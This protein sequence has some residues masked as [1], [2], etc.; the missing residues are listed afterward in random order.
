MIPTHALTLWRPWCWAICHAGKD[1]ENRPWKPWPSFL[2]AGGFVAIHSGAR[3]DVAG[4]FH[5]RSMHTD[6]VG[7]E[8][9][10][11]PPTKDEWPGGRIV[12]IARV[13][14]WVT[15]TNSRSGLT[16]ADAARVKDSDWFFGP[17]GWVL[18]DVLVL[19]EP[20]ACKGAQGLWRIPTDMVAKLR[21]QLICAVCGTELCRDGGCQGCKL[22]DQMV[23][24]SAG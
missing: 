18:R 3:W 14:G 22:A 5:L 1:V 7:V 8:P 15:E 2:A 10:P 6:R 19:R 24:E 9:M 21:N 16:G 17:V 12:A 4:E 11:E 23:A 20:L 13:V